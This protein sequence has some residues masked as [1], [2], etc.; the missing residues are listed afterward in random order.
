MAKAPKQGSLASMKM[1]V[2]PP[3]GTIPLL[4][5][6]TCTLLYGS[7]VFQHPHIFSFPFV[8]GGRN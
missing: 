4:E 3:L 2:W 6:N 1:M 8:K 5:F 7:Y